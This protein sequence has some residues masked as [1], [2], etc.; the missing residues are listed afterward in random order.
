M[1]ERDKCKKVFFY[2]KPQNDAIEK[3]ITIL[4]QKN[5]IKT[6][7]NFIDTMFTYIQ[8]NQY[9]SKLSFCEKDGIGMT[10]TT[11]CDLYDADQGDIIYMICYHNQQPYSILLFSYNNKYD[12]IYIEAVCA[13]QTNKSLERKGYGS[14]LLD[15]LIDA[16]RETKI[17]SIMLDSVDT[18]IPFYIKKGFVVDEKHENLDM[19]NLMILEFI[20]KTGG[21][22]KKTY[23]KHIKKHKKTYKK[24]IKNIKKTYKKYKK[25]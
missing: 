4:N 16:V 6:D 1:I 3:V 14:L 21:H 5:Y 18:A 24:Y 20:K 22:N 15:D 9:S 17:K 25:T 7:K 8:K 10:T 13:D 23:K 2:G 19:D 11:L 12:N